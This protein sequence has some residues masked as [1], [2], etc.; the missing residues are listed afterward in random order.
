MSRLTDAFRRAI[1]RAPKNIAPEKKTELMNG[2]VLTTPS[3]SFRAA[4]QLAKPYFTRSEERRKA[5]LLLAL[6]TGLTVGQVYIDVKLSNWGNDFY[7]NLQD[8]GT[9]L[10]QPP[11]AEL[12]EQ[13]RIHKDKAKEQLKEFLL[14]AAIYVAATIAKVKTAQKLH[15]DWRSW[16]TQQYM[17]S[18]I[19]GENKPYY[20]M[21]SDAMGADNPDQRI[22]EDINMFA[23]KTL[24]LSM[25]FLR[26]TLSLP[27]FSY[28]L[29][30]K[31][32]T[33]FVL[34][35]IGC[36]AIST[37][38]AHKVG[39]PLVKLNQDQQKYEANF[40][41]G[42]VKVRDNTESIALQD[43]ENVERQILR[44]L[45]GP[46][47]SNQNRIITKNMQMS[48]ITGFINQAA[49]VVPY[50]A[51]LDPFF[52]RKIKTGDFFQ[53]AG[54][55][56]QVQNDLSW[57][58]NSYSEIADWKS[59]TNRLTGFSANIQKYQPPTVG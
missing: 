6:V 17:T 52:D 15:L 41:Y 7:N 3:T 49:G 38:I 32:G 39:K 35:A 8:S 31:A 12:D 2:T 24:G 51:M 55:F 18:W 1:G 36:A 10:F 37:L 40:R 26:S 53:G 33:P 57:F 58:F 11:T 4:W 19:D 9:I 21:K 20:R 59:V 56:V 23:G 44:H 48:A 27:S 28:I 22:A 16:M 54:A 47:V 50:I 25:G 43:G 45:F 14:L 42:L 34:G 5:Q 13:A 30:T 46:I 29:W